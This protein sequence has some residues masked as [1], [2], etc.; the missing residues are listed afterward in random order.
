MKNVN[1]AIEFYVPHEGLE[2]DHYLS[3]YNK[4]SDEDLRNINKDLNK[5]K[6]KLAI[7]HL[8]RYKWAYEVL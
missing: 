3:I 8:A 1:E 6:I 7:H 5:R 2:L 4:F